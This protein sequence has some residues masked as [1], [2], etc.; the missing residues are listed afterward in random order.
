MGVQK[1]S[2]KDASQKPIV[3]GLCVAISGPNQPKN[4]R[5]GVNFEAILESFSNLVFRSNFWKDVCSFLSKNR[6]H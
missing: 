4:L 3:L 6:N 1:T 5:F 2:Q